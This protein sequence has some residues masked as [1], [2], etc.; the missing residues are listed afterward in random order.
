M[1]RKRRADA[2]KTEP[3]KQSG[4]GVNLTNLIALFK[5]VCLNNV[6]VDVALDI[7][8]GV[9]KIHALD[10]TNCAFVF[11][12]E[13]I[14]GEDLNIGITDLPV[15]LKIFEGEVTKELE[16]D[17][18]ITVS[19]NSLQIN[20]PSHQGVINWQLVEPNMISSYMESGLK[21]LEKIS[22]STLHSVELTEEH[23]NNFSHVHN[24]LKN[25]VITFKVDNG[26]ITIGSGPTELRKFRCDFGEVSKKIDDMEIGVYGSF[27]GPIFDLLKFDKKSDAPQINFGTSSDPVVI[28]QGEERT[29]VLIAAEVAPSEPQDD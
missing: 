20:L 15:L 23:I 6:I 24:I 3:K 4:E 25:E 8:D 1:A 19:D 21:A 27:L 28:R 5:A 16:G 17:F 13:K 18:P 7:E 9:G 29:W 26:K 22:E 12:E 10:P 14:G 2:K 11:A